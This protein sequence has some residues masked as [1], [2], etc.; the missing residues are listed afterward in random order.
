MSRLDYE[1]MKLQAQFIITAFLTHSANNCAELKIYKAND[2][3]KM[4]KNPFS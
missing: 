4:Q 1:L 3:V 2:V